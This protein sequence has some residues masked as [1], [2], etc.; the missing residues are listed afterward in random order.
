MREAQDELAEAFA[1][2]EDWQERYQ[3]I[4]DLGRALPEMPEALRVEERK[5]KGCQS[6]VWLAAERQADGRLRFQGAS[7]AA[8][9]SGLIALLL[10][11]YSGRTP[12][13]ILDT[14]PD[15]IAE[16]GLA[17]HLSPS[18]G[19]GLHAML[20]AIKAHAAAAGA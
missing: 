19:N 8:I 14:P 10:R 16:V 7:D 2:V 20:R 5:V 17:E 12:Q 3:Y 1:V 9:V 18:R 6:Q 11:I 13:A 4:I 15:F